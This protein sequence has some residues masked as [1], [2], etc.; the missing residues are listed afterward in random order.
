MKDRVCNWKTADDASTA[1]HISAAMTEACPKLFL[2]NNSYP[3]EDMKT[4]IDQNAIRSWAACLLGPLMELDPRG[5]FF[6]QLDVVE[7][8]KHQA[9]LEANK[10]HVVKLAVE[11]KLLV[12]GLLI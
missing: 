3:S 9:D 7:A 5:G 10:P 11:R 4:G 8:V 2:P 12:P 6:S 1:S